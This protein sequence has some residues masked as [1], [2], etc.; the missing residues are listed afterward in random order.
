MHSPA[1][2]KMD[3]AIETLEADLQKLRN[4]R[5]AMINMPANRRL[6]IDLHARLCTWNHTDGCGWFYEIKDG[7]HD[8]GRASHKGYLNSANAIIGQMKQRGVEEGMV[9]ALVEIVLKN[10]G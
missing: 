3:K 1:V 2:N 10:K 8:W 7:I 5:E 4:E 9:P 6:A